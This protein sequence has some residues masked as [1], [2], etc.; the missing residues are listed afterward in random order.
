MSLID[1]LVRG[2]I[3][4]HLHTGPD[5]HIARSVDAIQA[6]AQAAEAGMRAIVLK[7]HDYP[8]APLASMISKIVPAVAVLGSL[9]LDTA[10]G[11]LNPSA[12]E[13]CARLGGRVIW[14]PTFSAAHDMR[15]R[16]LPGEGI[17]IVD[18]GGDVLPVIKDILAI[19]KQHRMVIATGHVSHGE[20][21]ALTRAAREAGITRIVATHPLETR[22]GAT[23]GIAGQVEMADRGAF[24]EHCF[25]CVMPLSD[26][27]D[28][29]RIVE[30]VRAV[31]AERCILT[32]DLGQEW[33]PPPA[34]GMRMMVA[35]LL[36]CGLSPD[37]IATMIKTNPSR[38]LGLD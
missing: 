31:G 30:V 34:E 35:T 22:F 4:M 29:A 8:T 6:A 36:K 12:V 2:S 3:D 14:M 37:E 16:G 5:P 27:L 18:G 21:V 28:P 7:S 26:R 1:D 20:A 11:G 17:T 19:V 10:N 33:N 13:V 24:I 15:K 38:L 32:T 23:L 25:N 9:T